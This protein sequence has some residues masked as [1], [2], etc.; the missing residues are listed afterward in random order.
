MD[1]KLQLPYKIVSYL[2]RLKIEYDQHENEFFSKIVISAK[3][4]VRRPPRTYEDNFDFNNTYYRYGYDIVFFFPDF[5][6]EEINLGKEKS[7]RK[8]IL[9]DL[10]KCKDVKNEFFENVFFNCENEDDEEYRQAVSITDH[11]QI[12]PGTLDIWKPDWIRLFISHRDDHKKKARE[13][14]DALEDY[15]ISSFVAHDSIEPMTTWR[16]E[17]LKG[18]ETMESMLT[19]ITDDFHES[20]WTDQEIGFALARNVPILSLKLE[21]SDPTGFIGG[22]Q[23]LRGTL[24]H[25]A[26]SALQIYELLR[27]RLNNGDRLQ[28]ALIASFVESPDFNRTKKRFDQLN[29]V[30]NNL[31]EGEVKRIIDGFRENKQLYSCW[32]LTNEHKR[33]LNFL[34]RTTGKGYVIKNHRTISYENEN[35]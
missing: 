16:E 5:I 30:V 3:V 19:F 22:E 7:Y 35:W 13:L 15:G 8:Q 14:A 18:L 23:A 17:I 26:N 21:G 33:L 12:D 34:R 4:F 20:E 29:K 10:E 25:P 9:T 1:I 6:M 2:K 11:P 28:S 24:D 27:E 32:Y 31:S